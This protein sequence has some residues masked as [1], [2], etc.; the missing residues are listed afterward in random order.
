MLEKIKSFFSKEEQAPKIKKVVE[1]EKSLEAIQPMYFEIPPEMASGDFLKTL[2]SWGFIGINAVADEISTS[3][4]HL[5]S[6]KKE[7][8]LEQ[9][10]DHP[11]L[12]LIEK[13]NS[14]FTKQSFFWLLTVYLLAEGEAPI[15]F[16]SE[17][18]PK[19][20]LLLRPDRLWINTDK[21]GIISYKYQKENGQ[22]QFF[23]KDLLKIIRIP[24]PLKFFRGTGM[25]EY[26]SKTLSIDGYL[27]KYLSKFFYNSATPNGILRTD[28]QLNDNIIKRLRAQIDK[29]HKGVENAHKFMVLEGGLDYKQ[30]AFS[31]S[32]LQAKDLQDSIRDKIL[33]TLKVPKSVLGILEDSNRANT[34]ASDIVF[35]KRAIEPKLKL[36]ESYFNAFILPMFN[37]SQS[38]VVKYDDVV[39]NDRKI[40]A[41]IDQMYINSGV[42]TVNEVRERLGLDPI[43]TEE[44]EE[45]EETEEEET[46][47]TEETEETEEGEKLINPLKKILGGITRKTRDYTNE[48]LEEYHGRKI[49]ITNDIEKKFKERL[50]RY[51]IGVKNRILSDLRRK[52]VIEN[53]NTELYYSVND[54]KQV[55]SYITIPF[56]EETIERTSALAFELINIEDEIL[57]TDELAKKFIKKFSNK[58]GDSI[59]NT[60]WD[61]IKKIFEDWSNKDEG[62]SSLKKSLND[63]FQGEMTKER[64]NTI[65]RTEISRSA[66]WANLESFKRAGVVGKQWVT[67]KDERTCPFC[68]E[69]DGKA[70]PI[71]KNFWNEGDK[72][73]VGD[74]TLSF[75]YG[76]VANFPLHV[77]CRCNLRPIWSEAEIPKNFLIYK[78]RNGKKLALLEA[79]NKVKEGIEEVKKGKEEL[80][81]NKQKLNQEAE[82]FEKEKQDKLEMF[83]SLEKE[84][85]KEKEGI[86]SKKNKIN[87]DIKKIKEILNE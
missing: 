55:V 73:V 17:K 47:G 34:E 62:I 6:K 33:A 2:G 52:E 7:G 13:P 5:Y 40:E 74:K 48:M 63:F 22:Y 3:N 65:V 39:I 15:L 21:D 76:D 19:E 45:Q 8:A 36:I 11:F 85:K 53:S 60:T 14:I 50:D 12:N 66:G 9:I 10:N 27:E 46:E 87:K 70:I 31:I 56:L 80:E 16:D 41:E 20:M 1:K 59:A 83:N 4:F 71:G 25:L 77:N 67:A 37:S 84:I 54:E 18:N 26:I 81:N 57:S 82:L 58:A 49:Q 23:K 51:F 78:A 68:F 79:E 38:L 32:D 72:M 61:R 30:T 29:R 69:M 75:D 44:Q 24:N 35:S 42:Y 64:I 28:Q 86:K 43:E